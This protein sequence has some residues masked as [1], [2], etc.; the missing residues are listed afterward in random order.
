MAF[1]VL[2][3]PTLAFLW[4]RWTRNIWYNGHGLLMPLILGFLAAD[5]L[6]RRRIAYEE[7]SAWGFLF[8]VPALAAIAIDSAIHTELLA[9]FAMLLAL[10]GLSLLLLGPRRTRALAFPFA[11]SFF[12]LPIPAAFLARLHLFLR[13]RTA[14]GTEWILQLLGFSVYREGTTL[15]LPN[16]ALQVVEECSGFSALYAGI[17]IALVLAYMSRSRQ[18]RAVIL[19]VTIPLALACNVARVSVLAVLAETQGYQLLDTPIHVLSGYVTF[20]LTLAALFL[21]AERAPRRARA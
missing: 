12:M 21:F 7:P 19:A 16:G 1:L 8:L 4:D 20:V 2:C 9:A 18:R 13:E 15:Y 11:L 6:R 10:P 14:E 17:T 3:A 5:A